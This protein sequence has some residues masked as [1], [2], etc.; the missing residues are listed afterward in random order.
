MSGGRTL[1]AQFAESLTGVAEIEIPLSDFTVQFLG[2]RPL[3]G[4]FIGSR[5]P[6]VHFLTAAI[7]G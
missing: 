6:I 3:I 1:F 2:F 4:E 5:Q 7:T